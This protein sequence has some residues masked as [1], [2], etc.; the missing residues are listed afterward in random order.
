MPNFTQMLLDLRSERDRVDEAIVVLERLAIG[1]GKRRGRPPL[2]MKRAAAAAPVKRKPFS[3]ET[4][5]K[6]A[7]SQKARW[8]ARKAA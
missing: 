5:R 1:A 3:A 4:R 7:Q 8:A 6:M 2:W